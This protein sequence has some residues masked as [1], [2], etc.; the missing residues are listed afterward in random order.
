MK[1]QKQPS[2]YALVL[3]TQMLLA[4]VAI[5]TPAQAQ[6]GA[7]ST[8]AQGSTLSGSSVTFTWTEGAGASAYWLDIGSSAGGNNYYSSGNLGTALST[9]ANGLPT[10]GSTVYA[11]L[12][13]LIDDVWTPNAYTYTAYNPAGAGGVITSPANNSTL[14]G[15][16]VI[17]NWTAGTGGATGY[18][19]DIGSSAGGNNYYSSGNLGTALSTTATGL[20]TNGSAVYA[21]LYSL[22]DGVWTPNAYT[23]TAFNAAAA[24][25]GV[26]TTPTPS[27]TLSGSTVTFIWTAGSGTS[28]YWMDVGSAAGGNNYY[29]SGNLGSVLTVTATG[30]PTNGSTVYVTLYSQIGGVWTPNAYTYTAFNAAAAAGGVL[31]TPAPSSTLSGSSVTFDWTAGTGV[32]AYWMD[33]GSSAGGNNYYS[34]GNLGTALAT[35]VNGLPTNGS[36][37][38]V[39]LYS[40]IGGVWTPNAYTYTAFNAAAGPAV[41]QTPTPGSQLSTNSV[42]FTWSADASATAYWLDIGSTPGGGNVYSSGNLGNVL[43]TTDPNVPANGITLYVTLYSLVGGQWV[44]TSCTY[45]AAPGA[46]M[47]TPSPGSKLSGS[48]VTFTWTA[49]TGATGYEITVGSTYGGSDIYLSGNLGGLTTT[50]NNLPV[51]GSTIYV[52]L[53]SYVVGGQLQNYYRY[54]SATTSL[55]SIAVTPANPSIV[56]GATQQFTATGNYADGSQQN[57]TSSVTW[58]SSSTSVATITSA[59]LATGVGTGST[60]I[61]ATSG[62]ISGSAS[63]TV[64]TPGLVGYWTFNEGSGTTA[65]DSSGNGYNATLVN[66]VS[67][68]TGEIGDAVSANGTNQYVSIPAVNVSTTNA[69]TVTL[70]VNRTYSASAGDVLFEATTNYNQSTTGFGFFPDDST[71]GGIQ[72]AL[73]GNVGY[74]A[75]CYAQPSSG[76]WHHLAVVYDKSQT[77]ANEVSF[78][79]DGAPQ[80]ATKTL[81]ANTNTNDFGN[82]PI[83]LFSRGGASNYAAGIV[84]ELRIYNSA[85]S[86]SQI[87]Q[88]Y[89][90][91]LTSIVVTPA[92]SSIAAGAT[93]QFTATGDY[94]DG[95][96]QNLTNSVTWNSSSTAVATISSSGLATG[97]ATGSTTIQATSG[98]I[99]GSTG[100]TVTPPP[101]LVSIAVTPANSSVAAERTL[102]FTA[103]GTYS[104][105]SQQNLTS[106]VSWTSTNTAAAT[107]STTGL[108]TGVA[109]G[110]TTIQAAS[111]SINGS[112]GLTVTP[113]PTLVSIAVTPANPSIASGATQQFTATGTYSD[114]IQQNLTSSV[115]WTSTNTAVATISSTGLA[116]GVTTGSTTIQATSGSINGSTGLAV[117][118][119][120]GQFVQW[121]SGDTGAAHVSHT[122]MNNAV[123][124]GDL[125]LVFSHWDNQALTAS[126]TDNYGNTYIPISG[127]ISV[128]TAARFQAWYAKNVVGGVNLGVTITYSGTTTSISLVDAA[129]YSGLDTSAPL[130]VFGSAQGTG[131]SQNS[132]PSPA[133]T[134]S[135]ET[136]IGMFGYDGYATLYTAGPGFTFRDYDASS[137]LEDM[138]VTTNGNYTATATSNDPANWVAY[139]ICF[140]NAFQG[141]LSLTLNPSTV[142]AGNPVTGEVILSAPAPVG[143]ATVTL[144]SS[145][146]AVATVPA[147]VVVSSGATSA[148]FTV[149]TGSVNFVTAVTISGTYNSTI[150]NGTLTV[151]PVTM[152]QV[153]SDNFSR[154]NAPTLGPNWTPLVGANDVALQIVGTQVESAALTPSVGKEMYYGGLTSSPDQYSQAQIVAASGNGYEGPAVRMTSNDTHYACV[155]FNTGS[156]NAAVEIILDNAG[157]Y[158]VLAAS[159]ISTVNAL[160]TIRCTVQ[161]SVLTMTDQTTSAT[162]LTATD[163]TIPSGYPG[164]VDSAGTTAVTNYIMANWAAGASFAP[165]TAQVVASDNFNRANALNL[166]PNWDVGPGHGPIQIVNQQ[167]QPY[168]AGGPQPS[169]EHYVA[170]GVFPNDQWSQTQIIVEDILGDNAVEVRASDTSDTL[171]VLDVNIAGGPGVAETRISYVISGAITPLVIDQTWSAVSPGDYIRGQVQGNL[172]SLVDVTTGTLLLSAFDTN[173]TS[174]YPGI[175]MQVIDGTTTDHIAAK[176]SGGKFQ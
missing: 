86:A 18:W 88:I 165:L 89:E 116:T 65:A 163:S 130:D 137:M 122:Y 79:L 33:V 170:A 157:T 107:I 102:Q 134:A 161:G 108:A 174:G 99:N 36:T 83:Y 72:A 5:A 145:N 14:S 12:Y 40:Q 128:G 171:Y 61:Q 115:G 11:T 25:G 111:G 21:T 143:G 87:Q 49:G 167:V 19:L 124:N 100:L 39:T 127:P 44:S 46:V 32:S 20:P 162:L 64:P 53:I 34:S 60:K 105:G 146:P 176:W 152:S 51:N 158:S 74:T 7:M 59:G 91:T 159:T 153:A 156:G 150:Q 173:I 9:T 136:I 4:V 131:V 138:S 114:G 101:T 58:T 1:L 132:G 47:Q 135:N 123:T 42:T 26:L 121:S 97:V 172:L 82:N 43:T 80:T 35:T 22:I 90:A 104:D 148:P 112:T 54:I 139:V 96:Q 29:S 164:L 23:Y 67:W 77:G 8:P 118:P 57:L 2:W 141:P 78:Y 52:T 133:T 144:S 106:S 13:S 62:S 129:E 17:F 168:P 27:S 113:A 81:Y 6:G 125:I 68:V 98:S 94:S 110:S 16:S 3:F 109:T 140:K 66:G 84:D 73:L 154:S 48:S 45:T 38:Y 169:K 63:L 31:T 24:A 69:V 71:C 56:S 76:V 142:T 175:S 160:D 149:S 10:D 37:V 15:N 30:L 92:N 28:A 155:V 166:G 41:M 93:Q 126:V 147:N 95:S 85:L 75:N 103:T 120:P 117:T 50:V 55:V 151:V 119:P 70:W